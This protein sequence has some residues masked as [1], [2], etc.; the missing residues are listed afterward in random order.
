MREEPSVLRS[1]YFEARKATWMKG[2]LLILDGSQAQAS[3]LHLL[4]Q[5]HL[6]SLNTASSLQQLL[7]TGTFV[8]WVPH[9]VDPEWSEYN[10]V[11]WFNECMNECMSEWIVNLLPN[12]KDCQF[13]LNCILR[14]SGRQD[15]KCPSDRI[16]QNSE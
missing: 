5:G 13:E 15:K 10:R 6:S 14:V 16:L 11:A 2:S 4:V 12:L 9:S 1:I 7:V 3:G 8:A